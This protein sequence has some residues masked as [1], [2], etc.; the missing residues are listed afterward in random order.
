MFHAGAWGAPY[1]A[2]MIGA[3][4]ILPRQFLQAPALARIIETTKPTWSAGVPT[5]WNDLLRLATEDVDLSSMR[6]VCS[7]GA[8]ASRGLIERFESRFGVQMVQGWGMTETSP[9]WCSLAPA[10]GCH[11]G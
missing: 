9:L 1:G 5:I 11:Q 7:G 10:Q 6:S 3:D 4:I 8:A 2:F